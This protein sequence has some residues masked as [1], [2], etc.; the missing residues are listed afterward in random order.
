MSGTCACWLC[1]Y[2]DGDPAGPIGPLLRRNGRAT[3]AS[4]HRY[5]GVEHACT[6]AVMHHLASV[7][8]AMGDDEAALA[9][10]TPQHALG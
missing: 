4:A 8:S 3:L 1:L 2:D 5:F 7:Y 6:Q 10:R 9:V